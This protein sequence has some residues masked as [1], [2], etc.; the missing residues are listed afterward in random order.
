MEFAGAQGS[1]YIQAEP[2]PAA[3]PGAAGASLRAV[4][5]RLGRHPRRS[6]KI[7]QQ[8]ARAGAAAC[9]L[10]RGSGGHREAGASIRPVQEPRDT[11]GANMHLRRAD[12]LRY[13]AKSGGRN[14]VCAAALPPQETGLRPLS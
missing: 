2:S 6:V 3:L 10:R 4:G 5:N 1:G 7:V 12:A 11:E 13:Q 9:G 14:R 8:R